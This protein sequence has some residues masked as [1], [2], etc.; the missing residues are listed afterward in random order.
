[1]IRSRCQTVRLGPLARADA[2]RLIDQDEEIEAEESTI[3][4]VITETGGDV[5][6]AK[7]ILKG[8]ESEIREKILQM[9]TDPVPDP[10]KLAKIISEGANAAGKESPKRRAAIH[11][12]L[13]V[14]VS[15]FRQ[16]MRRELQENANCSNLTLNRLDRSMRAVR[17]IHRMANQ[18]TL[19]ECFAADVALGRTGDR[20]DIG[21]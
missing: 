9:I 3:H 8:Q 12:M 6:M 18:Q 2:T 20:G 5:Q 14:C 17:E 19:V 13:S 21:S 4:T 15:H 11:R 10:V 1:T 7:S 16:R